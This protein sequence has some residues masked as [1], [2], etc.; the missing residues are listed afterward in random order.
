MA[1]NIEKVKP[2]WYIPSNVRDQ[3]TEFCTNKGTVIQEDFAG[4]LVV[5]QH[6]P[7]EI[8]EIAKAEA[9]GLRESNAALWANIVS[10]IQL[11]LSAR[12]QGVTQ[13]VSGEARGSSQATQEKSADEIVIAVEADLA[14]RKQTPHH[15][16]PKPLA[17]KRRI[18][19]REGA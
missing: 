6:L 11:E 5:W 8:R 9:K 4:A 2:G 17:R 12:M 10:A 13:S 7:S 3:F 14:E 19:K 1:N 18:G 16:P 15:R